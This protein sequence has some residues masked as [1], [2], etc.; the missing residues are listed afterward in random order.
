[1]F[2]SSTSDTSHIRWQVYFLILSSSLFQGGISLYSLYLSG[3]GLSD[4]D[5]SLHYSIF[6]LGGILGSV[7]GGILGEYYTAKKI[8]LILNSLLMIA[9][10]GLFYYE[11][12][13]F[14]SFLI[15]YGITTNRS[16]ILNYFSTIQCQKLAEKALSWRRFLLNLGVAVGAWFVGFLLKLDS[17]YF[18]LFC[19]V[20]AIINLVISI[21]LPP[22][23]NHVSQNIDS[24]QKQ[25]YKQFWLL[26]LIFVL[27]LFPF[28]LIPNLYLLHLQSETN[29]MHPSTA[30][31]IFLVNGVIIIL[32]QVPI[33]RLLENIASKWKCSLGV[34]L[35]GLGVGSVAMTQN[36]LQLYSGVFLW[37]LGEIIL[38]VPFLTFFLKSSPFSKG[39][40]ISIYQ[41]C[42]AF[43]DF[44]Y[45][46]IAAQMILVSKFYLW[47]LV[48]CLSIFSS[49]F[50]F[51]LIK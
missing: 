2:T 24:I 38:F 37:T 48:I 12:F 28:A 22:L 8:S 35:I 14:F 20:I 9:V 6:G 13:S 46:L 42:F 45:P 15:G 47:I 34:L 5:V 43:S 25:G 31:T 17:L 1:M 11:P 18:L 29:F 40:T 3:E 36:Q 16:N 19:A 7:S 27:A 33:I 51:K 30:G 26:C 21:L 39:K 44:V 32:L 50:S 23:A 4:Y 10:S 41:L 49:I